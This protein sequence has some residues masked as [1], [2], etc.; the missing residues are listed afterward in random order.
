MNNKLVECDEHRLKHLLTADDHEIEH[1][2]WMQHIDTCPQCQARLRELAADETEW[3]QTA[4]ALS[5]PS[6]LEQEKEQ[7]SRSTWSEAIVKQLLESPSHP[8]MLGRL[9]RYEIERMIGSGG[10]GIVFKAFDS[11]LNRVVA[12]KLLAPHLS[13]SNSARKRFAREARAAAG[14]RDDHVVP[15]F[16]VESDYEPPFLVMQ[17]VAGGS[18][19]DKLERDGPLSVPEVLRIGLQ[20][21]KGLAAAHAQ[22]LIHRDVKPSN[23]LLDEGVERALLTDFGLARAEDDCGLTRT[24][25]QPGTPNYMSPEQVRGESIDGRSDLFGLGCLLYTLCT[26]QSPFRADTSYAI[27]R[28][29]TDDAPRS[30][31]ELNPEIPEWLEQIVMKLLEKDRTQRFSSSEEVSEMLEQWLAH[32]QQPQQVAPPASLKP[33][34]SARFQNG[35]WRGVTKYLAGALVSAMLLLGG[36]LIVLES[37]KGTIHIESEA[38]GVPIRITQ[39]DRV[40]ESL[41]ITK[42]GASVR[43]A[44]GVYV[45]EVEDGVDS[46]EVHDGKVSL[47]RRGSEVVRITQTNP[48]ADSTG[49]RKQSERRL[50]NQTLLQATARATSHVH[51]VDVGGRQGQS[52]IISGQ[53]FG[54]ENDARYI[55]YSIT[56]TRPNH[57][58]TQGITELGPRKPG[59][60]VSHGESFS[61]SGVPEGKWVLNAVAMIQARKQL[62]GKPVDIEVDVRPRQNT[63]IS[64]AFQSPTDTAGW[65]ESVSPMPDM[66]RKTPTGLDTAVSA[67]TTRL[68][69]E[70]GIKEAPSK[71]WHDE[72]MR[73]RRCEGSLRIRVEELYAD[74][75]AAF[76]IS[77]RV[78]ELDG[79]DVV[80]VVAFRHNRDGSW[81]LIH[82]AVRSL[83][84]AARD[85]ERFRKNRPQA[86]DVLLADH[87]QTRTPPR[88]RHEV[89]DRRQRDLMWGPRARGIEELFEAY[90]KQQE[91]EHE[92]QFYWVQSNPEEIRWTTEGSAQVLDDNSIQLHSSANWQDFSLDFR[93]P[94]LGEISH[95]RLEVLTSADEE[96]SENTKMTLFDVKAYLRNEK[97]E[98]NAVEF[99]SCNY[100]GNNSDDTADK[101]IDGMSDT[102]WTVPEFD[103]KEACHALVFELTEPI[104]V[105]ES[106]RFEL[107]IDSG[108]AANLLSLPRIRI[109]FSG[110]RVSPKRDGAESIPAGSQSRAT[111]DRVSFN[112]RWC[113]PGPFLMGCP[114]GTES[115]YGERFVEQ[116]PAEIARGFWM[117]ETEV[118]QAQYEA[119]V[120]TNPS[121]SHGGITSNDPIF[122][123]DHTRNNPVEQVSWND[124]NEFCKKL[125]RMDPDHLY[126]LPTEQEWEYA[127]RAGVPGI[128]YGKAEE[129][130]WVFENTDAGNGSIGHM[131]VARLEPNAWGL[132][133][134]LGNV[135]EWCSDEIKRN[136][137]RTDR[138]HRGDDCFA[139][140]GSRRT[141]GACTAQTRLHANAEHR[142]RT[143]GFRIVRE[144]AKSDTPTH[145]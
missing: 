101:C 30:I 126:R 76:G 33:R 118:T 51:S 108:G 25:V 93:Q 99:A 67:I 111:F 90:L 95:V 75:R 20:I 46:L 107:A 44:T 79:R 22:G 57:A 3:K 35:N 103:G 47:S 138:V 116:Q 97:N 94:A 18:L 128:R 136:D 130:A 23:V 15:V 70:L 121:F 8:E 115:M 66:L 102:G 86:E 144:R 134:M 29:I 132:Y 129:V 72:V 123:R 17:F 104:V 37:N 87:G 59:T 80:A 12:I 60:V 36:I 145:R 127:C 2:P 105:E 9:G 109:S 40:V 7:E 6:N 55:R 88:H 53:V 52:G 110:K 69:M 125:S 120:G 74:D 61:F 131:P 68:G 112:F 11:E 82:V 56:L 24:D 73:I 124:A 5:T 81:E 41:T 48:S 98:S 114:P 34:P 27:M 32:L 77:S 4:R 85:L 100:L 26:G 84:D 10:M 141:E 42:S 63:K 16:N 13:A 50:R 45:V 92:H 19:Q 133:D 137:G 49:T 83:D 58:K 106:N 142:S 38:D 71:P 14:V 96:N 39:G 78:Q 64:V 91:T 62:V 89:S 135:S 65:I 1:D 21:A 140:A 139:D 28:R 122:Q 31:R 54:F 143:L 113:P 117:G 43:V 119:V